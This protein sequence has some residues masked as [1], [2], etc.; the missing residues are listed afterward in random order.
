MKAL[1]NTERMVVLYVHDSTSVLSR[2][3]YLE[4]RDA[5]IIVPLEHPQDL[6][7][8]TDLE[9]KLLYKH[10]T[11]NDHSG[12]SRVAWLQLVLETLQR[13]PKLRVNVTEVEAQSDYVTF[14]DDRFYRFVPGSRVPKELQDL[15]LGSQTVKPDAEAEALARTGA[16]K[17]Y[18]PVA[19]LP[20]TGRVSTGAGTNT[21]PRTRSAAAPGA[22]RGGVR[23]IIWDKADQ[24]WEAA[25]KP[26]VPGI[27][28]K[29]RKQIMDALETDGVK[30]TSSSNELGNWQKAR[31]SNPT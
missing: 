11:G 9:L 19:A 14:E 28:L 17:E 10:T 16:V 29:L 13:I 6:D 12:F 4:N 26:T 1:I 27:V 20:G 24:M 8:F 25:G 22:P 3:D 30:R 2:M 5:S 31:V 18:A 15:F 21:A 7:N 23:Q